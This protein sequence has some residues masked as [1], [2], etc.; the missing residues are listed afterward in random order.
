[1]DTL[2]GWLSQGRSLFNLWSLGTES[3]AL[4]D[5]QSKNN[6]S[7]VRIH[8]LLLAQ[9][10]LFVFV[11]HIP[12]L[13]A[14]HY[15][16]F[17]IPKSSTYL[18]EQEVYWTRTIVWWFSV[19]SFPVFALVFVVLTACVLLLRKGWF[20]FLFFSTQKRV[21]YGKLSHPPTNPLGQFNWCPADID[22]RN[23]PSGKCDWNP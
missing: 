1:M 19:S 13:I 7:I 18:I 2:K 11:Y 12:K 9:C 21:K 5:S 4:S 22:V 17:Q 3:L 10:L 6:E 16:K 8:P 15:S 23:P 14:I 20:S